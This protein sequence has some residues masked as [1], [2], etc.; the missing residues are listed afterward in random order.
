MGTTTIKVSKSDLEMLE[1]AIGCWEGEW[2]SSDN[3]YIYR[4]DA[5][6]AKVQAAIE[7]LRD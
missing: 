6:K 4:L 2:C 7:E 5:V 3:V 1:M